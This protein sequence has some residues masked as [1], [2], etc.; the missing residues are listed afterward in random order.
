MSH[1]GRLLAI[2]DI[3]GCET[4]LRGVLA[5]ARWQPED[6]LVVLG[7]CV[8]RGPQTRQVL[9]LL[10]DLSRRSR[11][12][13]ILGNH[14]ELMLAARHSGAARSSWLDMG[15]QATLDSY[16]P[17]ATLAGIPAQHWAFLESFVPY[18]E[19]DSFIFTHANCESR[20]AM[21]E[22]LP[23]YLRWLSI[24]DRAPAPHFSGKTVLVGHTPNLSGNVVDFGFLRCIDT[25]CGLGGRLTVMDVIT[26]EIW[27]CES[28]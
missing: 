18:W 25:G 2:G 22:Q 20:T 14:E 23:S 16:G 4:A 1:T 10:L 5:L 21:A 27:Q 9:D 13:A 26:R 28:V 15:G 6:T 17:D 19:T 3:H 7:D 24:H 12:I 8:N 11:L